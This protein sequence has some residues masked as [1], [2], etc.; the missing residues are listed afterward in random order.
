MSTWYLTGVA[1]ANNCESHSNLTQLNQLIKLYEIARRS[2][3][4][5]RVTDH[6]G[7]KP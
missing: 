3:L 1:K 6:R 2:A 4:P 5:L 7:L